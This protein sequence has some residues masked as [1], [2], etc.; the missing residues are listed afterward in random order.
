MNSIC[1]ISV[2]R[3]RS[4]RKFVTFFKWARHG[5]PAALQSHFN[6]YKKTLSAGTATLDR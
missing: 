2:H 1:Y 3:T 5:F 4:R 6:R